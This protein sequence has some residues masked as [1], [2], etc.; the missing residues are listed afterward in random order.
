MKKIFLSIFLSVF[1]LPFLTN[2]SLKGQNVPCY[3]E[4]PGL[5]YTVQ[6]NQFNPPYSSD[7]PL[8]LFVGYLALD[9]LSKSA[10]LN[11]FND[12]LWRQSFNDTIKTMMKYLYKIIDYNPTK[13]FN[14]EMD[15]KTII[16]KS[17]VRFIVSDFLTF[18]KERSPNPI[19]DVSLLSSY[20]IGSITVSSVYN[21]TDTSA[22]EARTKS[23]ITAQI[24]SLIKGQTPLSCFDNLS[25]NPTNNRCIQFEIA[26]EWFDLDSS[27]FTVVPGQKYFIF[28]DYRYLCNVG[29]TNYYT[30]LPLGIAGS[31]IYPILD[32]NLIDLNNELG[33]G[34]NTNINIFYN[35][36]NYR[37]NEIIDYQP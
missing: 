27:N 6:T 18:I 1:I 30:I 37:I 7:M 29:T 28:C 8:D 19:L 10:N 21:Y 5:F 33:F 23:L 9:S 26:Q 31:R 4:Y 15:N 2:L 3:P 17:Q 14:F 11:E 35:N 24:D 13:Y 20:F 36:I 34:V 22:I 16:R 32:N 25:I 12:F